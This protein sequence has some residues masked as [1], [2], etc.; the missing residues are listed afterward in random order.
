MCKLCF[1]Q[2]SDDSED[3]LLF[4]ALNIEKGRD[5]G[6]TKSYKVLVWILQWGGTPKLDLW[7]DQIRGLFLDMAYLLLK[8]QFVL[9]K[10]LQ[11]NV[12]TGYIESNHFQL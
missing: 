5:R 7:R 9:V 3:S 4:F 1:I 8:S 6:E 12:K 10:D 2:Y 11:D